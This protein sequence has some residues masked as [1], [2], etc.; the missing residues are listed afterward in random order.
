VIAMTEHDRQVQRE[1][2]AL[3]IEARIVAL[4]RLAE[5]TAAAYERAHSALR[6]QCLSGIEAMTDRSFYLYH[7]QRWRRRARHQL[8]TK[9]KQEIDRQGFSTDIGEDGWPIDP[10]HPNAA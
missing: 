6:E 9:S 4:R 2:Q 1:V 8:K 10:N 3:R 5:A 7:T